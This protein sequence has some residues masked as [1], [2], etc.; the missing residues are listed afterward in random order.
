MHTAFH[1]IASWAFR[2]L[3][4]LP[5]VKV[6]LSGMT[7]MEQA[8]ENVEL[9]AADNKLSDNEMKVLDTVVEQF[10]GKV[11]IPCTKCH[12]C[13]GCPV[14]LDIPGLLESYNEFCVEPVP[15]A[16]LM[17]FNVSEN[18]RPSNCIECG[19]CVAYSRLRHSSS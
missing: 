8:E 18:K 4:N 2:W 7:T 11:N 13:D 5:N 17:G 19:S 15:V 10:R 9:F 12:Y 14:D 16:R 6:V 1:S 3:Q